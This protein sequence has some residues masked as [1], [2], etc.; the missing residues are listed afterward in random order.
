[1]IT[2]EELAQRRIDR[3]AV[4]KDGFDHIT[5]IRCVGLGTDPVTYAKY[6]LS[7]GV[8]IPDVIRLVRNDCIIEF[9]EA[10]LAVSE[11]VGRFL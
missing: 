6:L 4:K 9:P 8:T 11:A 7:K 5:C 1:M 2:P 3:L 10:K